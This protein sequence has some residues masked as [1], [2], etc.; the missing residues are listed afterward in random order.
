MRQAEPHR[1]R[2]P[3]PDS[4][5]CS[6]PPAFDRRIQEPALY[7]VGEVGA[8]QRVAKWRTGHAGPQRLQRVAAVVQADAAAIFAQVGDKRRERVERV[9]LE[10][11]RL[12]QLPFPPLVRQPAERVPKLLDTV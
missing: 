9:R 11:R 12:E 5:S 3:W 8:E 2:P 4:G 6:G 1:S 7:V 10:L